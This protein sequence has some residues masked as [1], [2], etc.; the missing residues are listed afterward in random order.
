M[1]Q[2]FLPV[3]FPGWAS[4]L[5]HSMAGN[6]GEIEDEPPFGTLKPWTVP[7]SVGDCAVLRGFRPT[8]LGTVVVRWQWMGAA[9]GQDTQEKES[10]VTCSLLPV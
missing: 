7:D 4:T 10:L 9:G 1:L 5:M 2:P 8:W 6:I 3:H